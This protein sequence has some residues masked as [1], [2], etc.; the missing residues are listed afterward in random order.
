MSIE[1]QTS[2][3]QQNYDSSFFSL[4]ADSS[5]ASAKGVI[6]A[7]LEFV[8]PKTVLDVGCGV[9]TWT[10]E[11]LSR[12]I[13]A[14]GIDGDYVDRRQLRIPPDRFQGVDLSKPFDL[15]RR[16]DMVVTLEVA[17]HLPQESARGF[18]ASLIRHSDL[19]LFSAAIPTQTGVHHVNEQWPTYWRDLFREQGYEVKDCIRPRIW[20][21]SNIQVCYRQNSLFFHNSNRAYPGLSNAPMPLN[22]VHP[23]LLDEYLVNQG[24]RRLI[25]S[26]VGSLRDPIRRRTERARALV[27]RK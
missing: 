26:L 9:G 15:G 3:A 13:D 2:Q 1:N 21:N 27:N 4:Q 25:S 18:V 16:F 19:I 20:D 14:Y 12:G 8:E 5:S 11:F 7:V 17:E 24:P 22:I 23:E 10:A 6:P